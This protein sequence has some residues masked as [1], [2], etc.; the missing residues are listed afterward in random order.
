M[1]ID[2]IHTCGQHV[3]VWATQ[4][5]KQPPSHPHLYGWD[6]NH[7][8]SWVMSTLPPNWIVKGYPLVNVYITIEKHHF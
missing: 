1:Y 8:E 6:F 2:Y 3:Q 4:C 7:P 5:Y